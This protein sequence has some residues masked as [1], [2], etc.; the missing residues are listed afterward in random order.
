MCID[1]FEYHPDDIFVFIF[2][3]M[4]LWKSCAY[5]VN[6]RKKEKD[7]P[8]HSWTEWG[9]MER[10]EVEGGWVTRLS[11][12][13]AIRVISESSGRERIVKVEWSVLKD[14]WVGE[15]GRAFS[16]LLLLKWIYKSLTVH[17]SSHTNLFSFLPPSLFGHIHR[18]NTCMELCEETSARSATE[19]HSQ[20]SSTWWNIPLRWTILALYGSP[21]QLL[22]VEVYR[23]SRT[24]LKQGSHGSIECALSMVSTSSLRFDW[25]F[26]PFLPFLPS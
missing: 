15:E 10:R 20:S 2:A 13:S 1:I 8:P 26:G 18:L 16:L 24:P 14:I 11:I 12:K 19:T 3:Q 22:F 21:S 17:Y 4:I 5:Q 23:V 25:P 7:N 9:P 6:S